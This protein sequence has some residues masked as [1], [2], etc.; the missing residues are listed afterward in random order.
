[1]TFGFGDLQL[2]DEK[3]ETWTSINN[4]ITEGDA[5]IKIK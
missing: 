1:M 4:G 2:V 5:K 3:G